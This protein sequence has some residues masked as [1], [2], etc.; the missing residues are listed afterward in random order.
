MIHIR[1]YWQKRNCVLYPAFCWRGETDINN[2]ICGVIDNILRYNIGLLQSPQTITSPM[3]TVPGLFIV[4]N[5]SVVEYVVEFFSYGQV[6]G[7]LD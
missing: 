3:L 7:G 2:L 1:C 4:I 6:L 5:R